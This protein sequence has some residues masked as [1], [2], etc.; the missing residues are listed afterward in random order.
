MPSYYVKRVSDGKA[1]HV[2]GWT[3]DPLLALHYPSERDAQS[4]VADFAQTTKCV[5]EKVPA[6]LDPGM[7][8]LDRPIFSG[9]A[10]G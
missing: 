1:Y 7:T 9:G 2:F 6:K 4:A 10:H 3:P 8:K 5:V